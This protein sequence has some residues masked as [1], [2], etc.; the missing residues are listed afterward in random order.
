MM[1]G[2]SEF[3]V[4]NVICFQHLKKRI[5]EKVRVFTIVEPEAHFVKV[6]L[7][8]LC[9]NTMPRSNYAALQQRK[10]GLYAV[11]VHIAVDVLAVRMAN[12]FMLRQN[13]SIVQNLWIAL[14]IVRH[15]HINILR[16]VLA[17]ILRQ[18][19][20]LHIL[21]V[22]KAEFPAA[23]PDAD[24]YLFRTLRVADLVLMSTLASAHEGFINFHDSAER[25]GVNGLHGISNAMAEIPSCPVVDSQHTLHLVRRHP[26]ARLADQ[27]RGKEPLNQRQMR[28][29]EHCLC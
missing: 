15:N 21:S 22:E 23:L 3:L 8:M 6:G 4:F 1:L 28:I 17:D 29:M 2:S 5:A 16:D 18:G 10:R 12:S 14:K 26:L 24:Y 11:R 9:A 27:E 20:R 13:T 7:Q 19:A 25:L